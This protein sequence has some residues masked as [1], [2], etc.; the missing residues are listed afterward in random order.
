MICERRR[1]VHAPSRMP[2]GASQRPS[3]WG[4]R[5]VGFLAIGLCAAMTVASC[6][7]ELPPES[8]GDAGAE[9]PVGVD[10]D[11]IAAA[12]KTFIQAHDEFGIGTESLEGKRRREGGVGDW[13]LGEWHFQARPDGYNAGYLLPEDKE[14]LV[15]LRLQNGNWY[16]AMFEVGHR[17]WILEKVGS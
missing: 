3:A 16:V 14:L 13:R 10:V 1:N 17:Y 6:R 9:E 7:E 15:Y 4:R 11:A 2:P 12:L 5:V 8:P